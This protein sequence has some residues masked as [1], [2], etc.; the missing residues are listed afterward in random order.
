[1]FSLEHVIE[2]VSHK[3]QMQRG[4]FYPFPKS[5]VDFDKHKAWINS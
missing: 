4:C 3:P 2:T 1:M 5:S